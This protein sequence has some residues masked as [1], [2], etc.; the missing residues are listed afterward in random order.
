MKQ[1]IYIL[2]IAFVLAGCNHSQ[3]ASQVTKEDAPIAVEKEVAPVEVDNSS[4]V[5]ICDSPWAECYHRY[6]DCEGLELCNRS[7]KEITLNQAQ[8]M[9]RRPCGFCER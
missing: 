2:T 4:K 1:L 6:S 7:I 8:K 3:Q 9:G 5:Y